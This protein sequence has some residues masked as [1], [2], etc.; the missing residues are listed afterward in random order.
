MKLLSRRRDYSF[1]EPNR[2]ELIETVH[3]KK[4]QYDKLLVKSYE[5]SVNSSQL[6]GHK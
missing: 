2:K 1:Q 4:A 5:P 6:T 3:T